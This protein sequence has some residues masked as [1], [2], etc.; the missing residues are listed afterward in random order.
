VV[1][2]T[3]ERAGFLMAARAT[4]L[5][6][7]CVFPVAFIPNGLNDEAVLP[8][9]AIAHLAVIV[10]AACW[11]AHCLTQGRITIRHSA[12]DWPVLAFVISAAL[13]TLTAFNRPL[14]FFGTYT[15]WEGLLTLLTYAALFWLA[16]QVFD[17]PEWGQ[18][19]LLAF[20]VGAALGA[21]V[22]LVRAAQE[23]M[24]GNVAP[25]ETA[26]TFGGYAR[27]YGAMANPNNLA[28]LLAMA[29]PVCVHIGRR[30]G[31]SR[32]YASVCAPVIGA[33]LFMTFGRAAWVMAIVG[34]LIA[35][36]AVSWRLVA[37][38]AAASVLLLLAALGLHAPIGDRGVAGAVV[39]RVA[40]VT[41][42]LEG[43][44]GTRTHIWLD[45]LVMVRDRP[46]V[47]YGPDTFGL[48]YPAY[49]SGQWTGG[50][51]IDKAHS[52]V[53]QVAAG[54]GLLGVAA[55]VAQLVTFV[56]LMLRRWRNPLIWGPLGAWLA[57]ALFIQDNFAWVP[58]TVPFWLLTA[59][60]L[61]VAGA[62]HPLSFAIPRARQSW[63]AILVIAL[64]FPGLVL[65][66]RP[67]LANA[68]LQRARLAM[69]S[70]NWP[71]AYGEALQARNLD[72]T[73]SEYAY[74]AGNAALQVTA[75]SV[76][77]QPSWSAARQH[78][79]DAADLGVIYAENFFFLAEADEQLGRHSDAVAAA[80]TAAR[81][82]PFDAG[83]QQFARDLAA[84]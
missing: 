67:V 51:I 35:L 64:A 43:S 57:Y 20:M 74:T 33:G 81:L 59:A 3:E 50:D 18:R 44:L 70:E 72:P 49:Q 65:A 73:E 40:S 47:G 63:A 32:L 19:L 39:S 62:A 23:T 48:V 7:T 75:G 9:L 22:G 69:D 30:G 27:A 34:V 66:V 12:M 56:V 68:H 82:A 58:I 10:T 36:A 2:A 15:R 6:T 17:S 54:Q 1:T 84:R 21:A 16:M 29:L 28:I 11:L 83:Y 71:A 79:T 46:V 41:H 37:A 52:D 13:S 53:L 8:K 31:R 24:A 14:A 80:A 5:V 61:V 55:Y 4:L 42:P 77:E 60:A 76:G 26:F 78:Y 25:G 38:L 45:T